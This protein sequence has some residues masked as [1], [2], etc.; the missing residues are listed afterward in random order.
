[1]LLDLTK[2]QREFGR[3]LG[4][5]LELFA[6]QNLKIKDKQGQTKPLIFNRAQQYIHSRLEDQKKRLGKVR[7]IILK[8]RQQG[9]STYVAARFY[10]KATWGFGQAVQILSHL[11]DTTEMLYEMVERFYNNCHEKLRPQIETL[12]RRTMKF[13][14]LDSQYR[15]GTAGSDDAGRGGTTQLFHGSEVA[16]WKK[17]DNIDTGIL[18]SV[19][20]LPNT[21]IILESTANGMGDL[22]YDKTMAAMRNE[23]DFELIFIPWFWQEE[24]KRPIVGS[25]SLSEKEEKIK[26]LYRLSDE[27]INWRRS[28]IIEFRGNEWKFLQ[29][30]PSNPIEAFQV[31]G[32]S[33]ISSEYIL[34]ARHR[35]LDLGAYQM[36]PLIMGVDPG[37]KQ[38]RATIAFRRG[39]K[40]LKVY[41]FDPKKGNGI[42]DQ[43]EL[44]GVLASMIDQ[45]KPMF[46]N[47]DVGEGSGTVA[48]LKEQGYGKIV[49]GVHFASGADDPITYSN[50]RAEMAGRLKDW[51]HC[52]DG[53]VQIPDDDAIHA[54][55]T[56]MPQPEHTSNSRIKMV[57]KDKI[58]KDYGRSPDIWDAI[59]LTFAFLV[60]K[61]YTTT[62][63]SARKKS[64]LITMK[65]KRGRTS[66]E[67]S[68]GNIFRMDK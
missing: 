8:G 3:Q 63:L 52:E 55:L 17:T 61:A 6:S 26:S 23:G 56:S 40:L 58:K 62:T 64:E 10:H 34:M 15:V 57:D 14:D 19:S 12:N 42:K 21:E 22:F 5:S 13:K 28:K 46:C 4:T 18:Q 16:F 48:R 2:E 38:D 11:S 41:V 31:S 33:Y 36:S 7:A 68:P 37:F 43:M 65:K 27:Q 1:M 67:F 24:Y 49:R 29:E 53:E 54:D 30:Y 35:K 44:A 32:E 59:A 50:K 45:Y 60:N 39:P 66:Q 47:I 25:F 20:D 51:I 9:C